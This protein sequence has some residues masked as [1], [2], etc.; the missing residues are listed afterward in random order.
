MTPRSVIIGLDV[1]ERR[2]GYAVLEYD[3]GNALATGTLHTPAG[4][5]LH[6]RVN[7]WT[8]ISATANQTGDIQLVVIEAPWAGPNKQRNA[9][10][11]MAIGNMAGV[12]AAR[13][14]SSVLVDTIQPATWRS[15]C[16]LPTR[17]K[18]PVHT[19]ACNKLQRDV[20]QDQADALGIA[21]AAHHIAWKGHQ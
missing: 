21:T 7:A 13:L 4:E 14:G 3:S 2:I 17:G 19:W 6:A 10:H 8:E 20:D 15:L 18:E 5:D 11:A 1:S 9:Q 12:A 16:G